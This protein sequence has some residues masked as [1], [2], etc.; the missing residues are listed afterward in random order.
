MIA[1]HGG[2]P[3]VAELPAVAWRTPNVYID[4][5]SYLP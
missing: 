4:I 5:A 3:W 2:W 1:G